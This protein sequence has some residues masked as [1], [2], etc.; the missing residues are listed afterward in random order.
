MTPARGRAFRPRRLRAR[1]R[2]RRAADGGRTRRPRRA[3]V[4]HLA[5]RH[6]GHVRRAGREDVIEPQVCDPRSERS[7][8]CRRRG[9]IARRRRSRP[10]A[11]RRPSSSGCSPPLNHTSARSRRGSL[12][13]VEQLPWRERVEVAGEHVEAPVVPLAWC[14]AALPSSMTRRRSVQAACTALQVDAEDP[15]VD[16]GGMEF[17]KRVAGEARPVPRAV[18]RRDAGSCSRAT[19][20]GA[21][22]GWASPVRWASSLDD[23][24]PH[25]LLQ[26]HHV[27]SPPR[28]TAAM[29]STRPTPPCRML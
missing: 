13:D 6:P 23:V 19:G 12:R 5:A 24:R 4:T 10:P 26:H 9:T 25:R 8:R 14:E 18:A 16:S 2:T 28:I 1:R 7:T 29:A 17:E 27:R 21:S 20:R 15:A 11:P 3:A 22:R